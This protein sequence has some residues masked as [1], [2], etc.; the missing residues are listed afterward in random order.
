MFFNSE[1]RHLAAEAAGPVGFAAAA[2]VAVPPDRKS[3]EKSIGVK[4]VNFKANHRLDRCA[5]KAHK[6]EAM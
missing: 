5:A 1:D 3:W 4:F 2:A 6:A